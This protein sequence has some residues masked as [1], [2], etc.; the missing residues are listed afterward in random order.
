MTEEEKDP[1]A[2]KPA[3]TPENGTDAAPIALPETTPPPPAQAESSA[4]P[5]VASLRPHR[6]RVH[7]CRA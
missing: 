2:G 3:E 1:T 7:H 5:E 6:Q 4:Q